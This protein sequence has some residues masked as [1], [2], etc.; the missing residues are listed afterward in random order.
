[1]AGALAGFYQRIPVGHVEAGM[2]S[3]NVHSPFPEE[4]NRQLIARL[5]TY[6]FAST[7]YNEACLLAEGV[8]RERIFLTGNP[9][10]DALQAMLKR[11]SVPRKIKTWLK[12]TRGMNRLVLT[13]HRRESL[14]N[15]MAQNLQVLRRFVE[16][17]RD[18]ALIFPVHPNP[19]V[20]RVAQATLSG[21]PRI[22][23]IR[24]LDYGDFIFLLSNAWLIVSDSGGVQAEAPTLGKPLLILR[25]NTEMPEVVESGVARLVGGSPE[26]LAAMLEEIQADDKWVSQVRK[27]KNPLGRGDSGK[28]IVQLIAQLLPSRAVHTS[29]VAAQ[30]STKYSRQE[31]GMQV[32]PIFPCGPMEATE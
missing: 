13:T 25:E 11:L 29:S 21:H 27:I 22:N 4:I 17:H 6:H 16:R 20:L 26:R 5:A 12:D 14:G 9:V 2:R 15:G 30:E 7:R 3:G 19:E 28:R 10:V 32:D 31:R 24:P 1:M 23:L 8:P 18:V